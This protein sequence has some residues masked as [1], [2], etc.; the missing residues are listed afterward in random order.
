MVILK[1]IIG[2]GIVA[3]VAILVLVFYIHSSSVDIIKVHANDVYCYTETPY[4]MN[5]NIQQ[6]VKDASTTTV[7][8]DGTTQDNLGSLTATSSDIWGLVKK[9]S[10][11]NSLDPLTVA[12]MCAQETGFG[13]NMSVSSAGAQGLMQIKPTGGP[14]KQ[15]HQWGRWTSDMT[16]DLND[17]ENNMKVACAYLKGGMDYFVKPS[18][19]QNDPGALAAGYNSWWPSTI[20]N[21]PPYLHSSTENKNYYYEVNQRYQDYK[22]GI[23]QIGVR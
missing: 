15:L 2:S 9:Y 8:V 20:N 16:T 5:V 6:E 23:K 12:A 17:N 4:K 19:K 14:V 3:I 11:L 10:D 18:G 7:G 13:T 1:R 22:N 21:N